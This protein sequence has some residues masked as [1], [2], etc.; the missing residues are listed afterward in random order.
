MTSIVGLMT[1]IF[2][3]EGQTVLAKPTD[4]NSLQDWFTK[5]TVLF[6]S[7]ATSQFVHLIAMVLIHPLRVGGL[8][9]LSKKATLKNFSRTINICELDNKKFQ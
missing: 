7:P 8:L 4:M 6:T 9:L 1:L 3:K 5:I 2:P